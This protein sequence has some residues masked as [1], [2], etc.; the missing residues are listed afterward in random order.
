[1]GY[2]CCSTKTLSSPAEL[3][4][5]TALP[6]DLIRAHRCRNADLSTLRRRSLER[7]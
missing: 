6:Y 5:T 4:Q 2:T 7:G 1:L 3:A